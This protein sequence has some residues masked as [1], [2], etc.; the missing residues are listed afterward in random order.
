MEIKIHRVSCRACDEIFYGKT[1][2]EAK[3]KHKKHTKEC[4][5]IQAW[6]KVARFH[7]KAEKILGKKLTTQDVLEMLG[8]KRKKKRKRKMEECPYCGIE[9]ESILMCPECG[10]EGCISCM[11]GGAGCVCPE[12]EELND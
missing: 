7:E 11:P 6:K 1:L 5:I 3:E 4:P 2:K 8:I 10:R 9:A 12:C